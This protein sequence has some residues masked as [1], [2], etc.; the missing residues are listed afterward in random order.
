MVLDEALTLEG[1]A[2]DIIR[3]IQDARKELGFQVT[4]RL[5][6]T[7]ASENPLLGKILETHQKMI[8]QE[9]LTHLS[10]KSL[11]S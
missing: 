2:R 8:M 3:A 7:L 5:E 9:T 10:P 11:N 6:L 1:Y 4:D